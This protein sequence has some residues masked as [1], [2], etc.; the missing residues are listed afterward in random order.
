MV[1]IQKIE[2]LIFHCYNKMKSTRNFWREKIKFN[3]SESVLKY[4]QNTRRV[5]KRKREENNYE[6]ILVQTLKHI[7]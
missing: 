5:I 4:K 2:K 1:F 6:I 7:V 3:S